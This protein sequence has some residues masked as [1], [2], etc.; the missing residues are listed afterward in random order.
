MPDPYVLDDAAGTRL[1]LQDYKEDFKVSQWDVK[2]QASWKLERG[3]HF[4]EPGFPS[5]EAFARGDWDKSL[6]LMDE[7]REFL[8]E[9]TGKAKDKGI[10]L[11]R[12]RVVQQP[13]DPYLQWEL[14]LL[15][16]RAECG[17]LIRVASMEHV[18][19]YESQGPLP[20]LVTFGSKILY[21]VVYND[22]GELAGAVKFSSPETIAQAASLTRELYEHGED[23][24]SFFHREV[25]PLPPPH[26]ESAGG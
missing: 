22:R 15:R 5:W 20:E 1:Q 11:Y 14:H 21:R 7:E 19:E 25:A 24:E 9:F 23:L 4:R 16:L 6:Q 18:T 13:I 17:E 12:V 10:D 2:G 8:A 26:G 3:Q